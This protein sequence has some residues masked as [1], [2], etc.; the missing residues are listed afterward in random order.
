VSNFVF[1]AD[2]DTTAAS[3]ATNNLS[4]DSGRYYAVQLDNNSTAADRK[5]VV[6][7]PWLSGG[8][9]SWKVKDNTGTPI[10]KTLAS[11]E[12]LQFIM[13]SHNAAPT[14]TLTDTG[15]SA[16]YIMTLTGRDTTYGTVSTSATGLAPQL[17]A[18]HGGKFLRADATWVVPP[19]EDTLY[20]LDG[21][22]DASVA[23][24]PYKQVVIMMIQLY[25]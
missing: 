18:A 7:V 22:A 14:A 24:Y 2:I 9:Y 13:A 21:A 17:P 1:S 20:T 4:T 3:S 11:G 15:G 23:F 19:D 12:T 25:A 6:N 8:T 10:V 5:M 16:P